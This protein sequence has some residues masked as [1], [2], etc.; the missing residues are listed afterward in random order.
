MQPPNM[1]GLDYYIIHD[2]SLERKFKKKKKHEY[3]IKM[4]IWG[5]LYT[6]T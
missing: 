4:N 6:P 3:Y 5:H 2:T 1:V